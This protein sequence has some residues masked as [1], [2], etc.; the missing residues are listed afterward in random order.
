MDEVAYCLMCDETLLP[1]L[2]LFQ[3]SVNLDGLLPLTRDWNAEPSFQDPPG[4]APHTAY[5]GHWVCPGA[6][7]SFS[8]PFTFTGTFLCVSVLISLFYKNNSYLGLGPIPMTSYNLSCLFKDPLSKYN[9]IFNTQ[10]WWRHSLAHNTLRAEQLLSAC[11]TERPLIVLSILTWHLFLPSILSRDFPLY[12]SLSVK[13]HPS[14]FPVNFF[15]QT[16]LLRNM[17]H[18]QFCFVF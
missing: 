16:D 17:C 6:G 1:R 15:S 12:S 5:T 7:S 14:K 4:R 9:Q 2:L 3:S 11:I 10:I 13:A 8:S 18:R